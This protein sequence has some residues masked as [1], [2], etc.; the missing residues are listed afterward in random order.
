MSWL[1]SLWEKLTSVLNA[2]RKYPSITITRQTSWTGYK[3]VPNYR[4]FTDAEFLGL[5]KELCAMLDMARGI[6]GVPFRLT[7][8]VNGTHA[9]HSAHYKGLA[10]DIGL[11]HLPDGFER[12]TQRWAILKGLFAAGFQRIEVCPKHIHVDRGEPPDFVSPTC[13][14][15]EDS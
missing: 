4:Y 2:G 7:S 15:G 12:N 1:T 6:A 10:V 3:K 13:W 5:D 9:T 11:G 8:T 14:I